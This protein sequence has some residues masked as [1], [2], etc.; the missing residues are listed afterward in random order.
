MYTFLRTFDLLITGFWQ[1]KR[2]WSVVFGSEPQLHIGF[3]VSKKLCLNLC[4]FRRLKFSIKKVSNLMLLMSWI[5]KTEFTEV[6]T[7]LSNVF[8]NNIGEGIDSMSSLK[9]FHSWEQLWK[10]VLFKLT[11]LEA[12]C[13]QYSLLWIWFGRLVCCGVEDTILSMFTIF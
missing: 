5:A 2:K 9:L 3:L 12:V 6:L 4:S 8:L 13:L 11:V 10:N 7:K 1:R